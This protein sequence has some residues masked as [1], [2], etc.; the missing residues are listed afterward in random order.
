MKKI[1]FL[2]LSLS[3]VVFSC[4]DD[5]TRPVPV[6][7]DLTHIP[8][9]PTT[10]NLVIPPGF[11]SMII[12]AANPLTQEGVELGRRLFY[13][14]ILSFDS[15]ISCASCHQLTGSFTDNLAFSPG[16]GKQLGNRS[17]MSLINVGFFDNG[18]FWDGRSPDLEE[19]AI[20]PVENPVEMAENW[21]KVVIKLRRHKDYP[22]YFRKAFGIKNGSEISRELATKAIA[23]FERI[24]ISAN[25]RF[26]RK[27]YQ[28]DPDPFL[29]TEKEVDGYQLYF[30]DL[31][32]TP[33]GAHCAHCHDGGPLLTSEVY[34]NNGIEN[35]A[36][37]DDFPD[38]GLGAI[39]G[40][41]IDNGKFRAPSLRNIALTAPY[42]HDGRFKTLEE[43]V[44][45]YNSGGHFAE[46]VQASSIQK[47]NL[48]AYEKQALV[49]F[50]HTFTDTSFYNNPA[51]KNP[52]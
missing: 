20:H 2:L 51:L 1:L 41:R 47:L 11:P 8:Y 5:D 35:V 32:S 12:P 7:D 30:D 31:S 42:M 49:A 36:T 25:S 28:Q 21:D 50:L 34:H 44:E 23:Q 39:T 6:D 33:K 40:K 38:K 46:N 10:Y 9:N 24:I 14:P 18:L 43:V 27:F 26:D 17:T 4:K 15:T 37:L 52:F 13:D 45:H 19:Q 48:T 22:A 3:A 29:L 16:V